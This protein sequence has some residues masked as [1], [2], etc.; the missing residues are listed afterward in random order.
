MRLSDPRVLAFRADAQSQHRAIADIVWRDQPVL[1][2]Q[3]AAIAFAQGLVL[4]PELKKKWPNSKVIIL[5]GYGS[6]EVAEGAYKLDDQIFLQSKP[7]DAGVLPAR[8]ALL[9]AL[10]EGAGAQSDRPV[11]LRHYGRRRRASMGRPG[12]RRPAPDSGRLEGDS[13]S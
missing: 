9:S 5:T 10:G 8:P 13:S 7:F 3:A 11:S 6:V 1:R 2:L 4:L 12:A